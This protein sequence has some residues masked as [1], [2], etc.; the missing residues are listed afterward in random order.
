[1]QGALSFWFANRSSFLIGEL[2]LGKLS[3]TVVVVGNAPHD[4]AGFL[5]SHL[6]GN[7]HESANAQGPRNELSASHQLVGEIF[8]RSSYAAAAISIA[9]TEFPGPDAFFGQGQQRLVYLH[10]I[11]VRLSHGDER[12][13]TCPSTGSSTA[14][15]IKSRSSSRLEL[16]SFM[17]GCDQRLM[18]WMKAS[19]PM[20]LSGAPQSGTSFD[21]QFRKSVRDGP[22]S[23]RHLAFCKCP[24]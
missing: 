19:S 21:K 6:I 17:P 22:S 7:R 15:T 13:A 3:E 18:D 1:M 4:R 24:R 20:T 8:R 12:L 9:L 16:P 2:L 10:Q 14:T 5:V 11:F 23:R